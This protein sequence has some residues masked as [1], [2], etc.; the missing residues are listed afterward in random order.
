M[1]M[2]DLRLSCMKNHTVLE[3]PVNKKLVSRDTW[4]YSRWSVLKRWGRLNVTAWSEMLLFWW[5]TEDM[6]ENWV[7]Y[8]S[9]CVRWIW[10]HTLIGNVV[11]LSFS[12]M[13]ACVHACVRPCTSVCNMC[14][15]VWGLFRKLEDFSLYKCYWW[16]FQHETFTTKTCVHL[17]KKLHTK[18]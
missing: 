16:S 12:Y 6:S 1:K 17:E 9:Q 7:Q 15:C 10:K 3:E 18:S 4:P 13:C 5:K 11:F 14:A 2:E 8:I